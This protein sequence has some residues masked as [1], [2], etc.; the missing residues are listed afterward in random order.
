MMNEINIIYLFILIIT[1]IIFSY[2]DIKNRK[3]PNI[4]SL[5]FLIITLFI[6]FINFNHIS[7]WKI[8]I[9][10]FSII[11]SFLLYHF[12]IWGAADGKIQIILT[13]FFLSIS[14][15][16]IYLDF[17][18]NL[19]LFYVITLIIVSLFLYKRKLK[20][21]QGI[22]YLQEISI[23][24]SLFIIIMILTSLYQIQTTVVEYS[25]FLIVI[26]IISIF[27]RKIIT[28]PFK[29][30]NKDL[31]IILP[32]T[33]VLILFILIDNYYAYIFFIITF[34]IRIIITFLS[35]ISEDLKIKNKQYYS[36]FM[37][38]IMF[39]A[40]FTY[41]VKTNIIVIMIKFFI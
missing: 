40:I 22:Q 34:F 17:L 4:L 38:Y 23:L 10:T 35:K 3:N 25:I 41:L 8:L 7:P 33:L 2:Y 39:S 31:K 28:K 32:T 15:I 29:K 26:I 21:I 6:L 9:I 14:E 13:I 16:H 27:L 12:K 5:I 11:I 18:I 37:I 36:P 20:I 19:F 1:G 24:A 30:L